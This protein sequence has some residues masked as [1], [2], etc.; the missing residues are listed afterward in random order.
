M[1]RQKPRGAFALSRT[2]EHRLALATG[3][4]GRRDGGVAVGAFLLD[5]THGLHFFFEC[6]LSALVSS[7]GTRSDRWHFTQSRLPTI[8]SPIEDWRKKLFEIEKRYQCDQRAKQKR[9]IGDIEFEYPRPLGID[10]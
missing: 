5:F 4:G 6:C 7:T 10:P 9:K 3:H 1:K 2:P 8:L